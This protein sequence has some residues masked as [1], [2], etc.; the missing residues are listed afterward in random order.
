MLDQL[1]RA[2]KDCPPQL[3]LPTSYEAGEGSGIIG[4]AFERNRSRAYF[5]R[6]EVLTFM[7][8]IMTSVKDKVRHRE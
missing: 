3:P 1:V 2:P 8:N 6:G 5:S 4:R 7:A